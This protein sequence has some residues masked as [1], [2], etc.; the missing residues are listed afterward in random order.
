MKKTHMLIAT[1]AMVLLAGCSKNSDVYIETEPAP[2]APVEITF[3]A[4]QAEL[5]TDVKTRGIGGIGGL[6]ADNTWNGETLYIYALCNNSSVTDIPTN[7][8]ATAPSNATPDAATGGITWADNTK[9]F[10]YDGSSIY[11]FYGYHIDDATTD[12]AS[13]APTGDATIGYSVPFKI[14]GTQDLMVAATDRT[15]DIDA[16]PKKADLAGKESNLYSA[17]SAR[18]DVTPNLVFKHLLSRLKFTVAA[19]ETPAPTPSVYITGIEVYS[20]SEGSLVVVPSADGATLQGLKD[21]VALP[22]DLATVTPFI[23]MQKPTDPAA[24]D[25]K[26]ISLEKVEAT[27]VDQPVGESMLVI[28]ANSYQIKIYTSQEIGGLSQTATITKEIKLPETSGAVT[29]FDAG[30]I[31]TIAIKVYGLEK[32]NVNATLTAWENGGSIT[33][34]PDDEPNP[35]P[36]PQP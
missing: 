29:P 15:A 33:V 22:A 34:D 23:L 19:G 14:D 11:T 3:G 17:W 21:V 32:I 5:K 28:P 8:E 26:L 27:D 24:V 9:H 20:A 18:R 35:T 30:K 1:F 31:Y 10:Y 12:G 4:K 6:T 2:D 13:P 7:E 25:K 36:A 16:S